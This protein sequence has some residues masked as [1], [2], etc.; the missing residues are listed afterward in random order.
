M[1]LHKKAG[2][3]TNSFTNETHGM[4]IYELSKVHMFHLI[5]KICRQIFETTD[6]KCANL[7]SVLTLLLK[8]F[9]MR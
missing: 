8:V 5:F 3:S 4:E 1:A 9:A 7:K 2:K 6:Y